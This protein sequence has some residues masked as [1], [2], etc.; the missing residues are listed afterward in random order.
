[1]SHG[2]LVGAGEHP[3]S[4]PLACQACGLGVN[5]RVLEQLDERHI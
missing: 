5:G 1:L 4:A 2:A 3:L